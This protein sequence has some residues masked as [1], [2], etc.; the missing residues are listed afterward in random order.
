MWVVIPVGN[1][2]PQTTLERVIVVGGY[3]SIALMCLWGIALCVKDEIRERREARQGAVEKATKRVA[4]HRDGGV[5]V[6]SDADVERISKAVVG[7][8]RGLMERLARY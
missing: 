1:P 4:V 5:L 3:G 6:A 2:D 8:R 7:H